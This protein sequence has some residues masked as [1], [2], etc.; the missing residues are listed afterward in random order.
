MSRGIGS[1]VIVLGFAL[2]LSACNSMGAPGSTMSAPEKSL[3]E[4]LGGNGHH[5]RGG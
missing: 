1:Y 3:Y 4:R 2:T 5:G